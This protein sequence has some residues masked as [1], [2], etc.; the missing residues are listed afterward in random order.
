MPSLDASASGTHGFASETGATARGGLRQLPRPALELPTHLHPALRRRRRAATR[1][2]CLRHGPRRAHTADRELLNRLE[3]PV[4]RP[5]EGADGSGELVA[6]SQRLS[7]PGCHAPSSA[8]RPTHVRVQLCHAPE[9]S[10]RCASRSRATSR[11]RDSTARGSPG[12]AGASRERSS[13]RAARAS[14]HAAH[15]RE[16]TCMEALVNLPRRAVEF[17]RKPACAVHLSSDN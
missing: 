8:M 6:A 5:R 11:A 3:W 17:T 14:A 13:A 16:R 15:G 2:Q 10:D 12:P 9:R 7:I 1:R 4:G